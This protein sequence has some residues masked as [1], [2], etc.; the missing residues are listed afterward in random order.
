MNYKW[1]YEQASPEQLER[2]KELA[3]NLGISPILG[4]FLIQRG[5]HTVQEAKRFFRPQLTD[6]HDPFLYT[7][8]DIAVTRLNEA[9]GRKERILVYGDYDVDGC[10]A[11]ALVYKFLQQ[12]YS[13][14]DYYIPDRYEEGYGVSHKGVDFAYETGVKLI[15]VLDCGI[16]AIDE[17]A[18][19][20]KKGIDFIICDHHVPD[21]QLPPAIAI[22]NAKRT[23]STYPYPHLSGCGV[24]F[25][26]MQAFAISNGIPFSRLIP[27]LDLCA[28]SI[29]S[30]IVPIMGENRILAYHGLRQLNSNPSIGLKAIIDI[31]GLT[32][33]EITIN[34]IIFKIGPRINASG[35][36]QNGKEA[37]SLLVE[38]NYKTAF[39]QASQINQYNE[40]RKDLDKAMTEQANQ[41]VEKLT[42]HQ[43]QKA[44]V[45]YNEEWHKGVIGIVASRLTE[46]YYRPAVVLTRNEDM[47]TGS[48]R[49]VA[50]FDVYSAIASC[51]DLLENFGGH[52]YAAGL[53]MKAEHVEEFKRRFQAY[54]EEHI[55]PAQTQPIL[56]IDAVIGFQDITHKL[57]TDLKKFQPFG[58]DNQKPVFCTHHVYDYG[59]SKVV[60]RDQEHIKLELVDDNS[61][62]V[63]NGIA[64][65]Q[66]SQARYIKT[67]HSFDIAYTLEDNTH[68]RGEI[69]LQIEDI[70]PTE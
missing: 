21:D 4:R 69:Q 17:I 49:S 70:R 43:Q 41:I 34:D 47:A 9:L 29:A 6:L 40:Q 11:V 23:E 59:T 1:S 65:G 54:V 35:R 12:F 33:R 57:F 13:N 19:A 8:M 28:V 25:K 30:D 2:A 38:R 27:L 64:F 44:I 53:S 63:M 18:Y 16:K 20:K 55:Q 50:G 67:K 22:L 48:A 31:C 3:N 68:K 32:D 24:G 5:I 45:I 42:D 62:H 39:N 15:I 66:S 46:I 14:V 26:L 56:N 7:D 52:T 60:G 36:M 10:T 58:P 61:S 51:R 37:V